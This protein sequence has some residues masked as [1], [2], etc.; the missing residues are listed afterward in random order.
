[1]KKILFIAILFLFIFC[2]SNPLVSDRSKVTIKSGNNIENVYIDD[3]NQN[4]P[5]FDGIYTL[6]SDTTL[7]IEVKNGC[8]VFIVQ[9][10]S[11][12]YFKVTKD[13]TIS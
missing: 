12:A 3:I 13:T 4:P 8:L 1:M 5:T 10:D 6:K 11:S 7:T 2:S 9:N